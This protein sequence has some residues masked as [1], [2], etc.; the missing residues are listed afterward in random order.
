MGPLGL[1]PFRPR[2]PWLGGDLQTLRDSIRPQHLALPKF[3]LQD[4]QQVCRVNRFG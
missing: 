4:Q 2:F 1:A 3:Q